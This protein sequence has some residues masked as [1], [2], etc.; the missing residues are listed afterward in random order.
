MDFVAGNNASKY[1]TL[2]KVSKATTPRDLQKPP[3]IEDIK[4]LDENGGRSTRYQLDL[5]TFIKNLKLNNLR[6][7]ALRIYRSYNQ[8]TSFIKFP[9][10]NAA[11]TDLLLKDSCKADACFV[12]CISLPK[13]SIILLFNSSLANR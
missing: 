4:L 12:W 1:G 8:R 9:S 3:V 10:C 7:L 11:I 13:K 6:Y 2:T 5:L